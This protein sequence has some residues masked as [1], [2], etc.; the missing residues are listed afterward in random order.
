MELKLSNDHKRLLTPADKW[1][2][3]NPP[4]DI[5]EL[6]EGMIKVLYKENGLGIAYNQ[7]DLPGNYAVFAMR[8]E[9]ENFVFINPRI[10]WESKETHILK[11]SC[12]SF[13]GLV[14]PIERPK[15]VRIRFQTPSGETFTKL[16][17]NLSARVIQ[18]MVGYNQGK[19][20]FEGVSRLKLNLC[21]KKTKKKGIDYTS[22]GLLK[23]C[24]K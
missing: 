22:E 10:V 24:K 21:L 3:N 2:F 13:K 23:F 12:L 7:L 11:E 19:I 1:D 8:G 15:D 18:Q 20:F 9:P 5:I 6:S 4:I 17:K 14:F 16:F